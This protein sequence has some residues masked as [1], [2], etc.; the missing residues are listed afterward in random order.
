MQVGGGRMLNLRPRPQEHQP[1][2]ALTTPLQRSFWQAITVGELET[3]QVLLKC[4][5]K[6]LDINRVDELGE[7]RQG[8]TAI[9]LAILE[10]PTWKVE[11][12]NHHLLLPG[13]IQSA[14]FVT[15]FFQTLLDHGG[16][17]FKPCGYNGEWY[18]QT[19]A[20][21][22]RSFYPEGY[23][24]LGLV[25]QFIEI[26]RGTDVIS[27]NVTKRL[28]LIRDLL[29]RHIKRQGQSFHGKKPCTPVATTSLQQDLIR[30]F[31]L[32][33]NTDVELVCYS[34]SVSTHKIILAA[35]SPVFQIMFRQG[36]KAFLEAT[37]VPCRVEITQTN[38]T[39]LCAFVRFLYVN[40][41]AQD[42]EY[43]LVK[44]L[45][46]LGNRYQVTSLL[47]QS[48]QQIQTYFLSINTCIEILTLAT[49]HNAGD[50]RL[51]TLRF[52]AKPNHL[53]QVTKSIEFKA[54]SSCLM[55]E[56]LQCVA[57]KLLARTGEYVS[58]GGEEEEEEEDFG[59][60]F[61]PEKRHRGEESQEGEE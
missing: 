15:R 40:E 26:T 60:M 8:C 59:E 3:V 61:Q 48:S 36:D 10:M 39:A 25:L 54:L 18:L 56:V 50:L 11:T 12:R 32:G 5:A 37:L 16:D 13:G 53:A 21:K 22:T 23:D 58:E 51:A 33:L 14:E 27:A 42:L 6:E 52:M 38:F 17:M 30:A 47:L 2:P 7:Q 28:E 31:E 4:R 46:V 45:L 24:A 19:A 57:G 43:D 9:H 55:Q 34:Q 29:L 49:D 1:L 35:R 44:D 20:G 41:L